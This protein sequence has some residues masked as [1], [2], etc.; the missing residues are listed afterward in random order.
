MPKYIVVIDK[1]Y[2]EKTKTLPGLKTE[3]DISVNQSQQEA[4]QEPRAADSW[5][6]Q[7]HWQLLLRPSARARVQ[8]RTGY[9]ETAMDIEE[10]DVPYADHMPVCSGMHVPVYT[11][12]PG[13]LSGVGSTLF[14]CLFFSMI[15]NSCIKLHKNTVSLVLPELSMVCPVLRKMHV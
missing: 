4:G 2:K 3:I 7:T 8:T 12:C 14:V 10:L 6:E 11:C 9:S 1:I 15:S 13:V 5:T